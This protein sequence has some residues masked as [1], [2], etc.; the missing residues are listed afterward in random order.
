MES[1]EREVLTPLEV[2]RWLRD[3]ARVFEEMATRLERIFQT[4]ET[5]APSQVAE[6]SSSVAR[7]RSTLD[8]CRDRMLKVLA[9]GRSRRPAELAAEIGFPERLVRV[10]STRGPGVFFANERGWLSVKRNVTESGG[11]Q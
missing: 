6:A 5:L 2:I 11:A 8:V 3:Q 7:S 4:A 10:V 9:D 1:Q